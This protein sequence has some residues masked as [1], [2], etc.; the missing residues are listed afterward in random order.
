[1]L[2]YNGY[3]DYRV[4]V[5]KGDKLLGTYQYVTNIGLLTLW[6]NIHFLYWRWTSIKVF[7]RLSDTF[8]GEY[9]RGSDIP[10]KPQV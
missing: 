7:H 9:K 10:G 6:L 2:D 8:I 1:M 4:E 5:Y 3:N